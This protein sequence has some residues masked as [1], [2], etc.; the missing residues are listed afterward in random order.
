M[1][2]A[3]RNILRPIGAGAVRLSFGEKVGTRK[4]KLA[5]LTIENAQHKNALTGK[6][7]V[8]LLDAI[9]VLEKDDQVSVVTLTGQGDFFCSGADLSVIQKLDG[10]HMCEFMQETSERLRRLP[11]ISIAVIRGGCVGGGTELATSCDLRVFEADATWRC[12]HPRMGISPGWGGGRRLTQLVGRSKAIDLL[13]GSR[14]LSANECEKIGLANAVSPPFTDVEEF[15]LQRF[16]SFLD[17]PVAA[18]HACKRSIDA[19]SDEEE[20]KVFTSV[21]GGHDFVEAVAKTVDS[22]QHHQKVI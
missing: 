19:K 12:V 2:A 5:R 3:L 7:M 4:G 18:V 20:R 13:C 15:A 10:G 22:L 1:A 6:M 14:K 21:W 11:A 8:D 16:G 17:L 9:E